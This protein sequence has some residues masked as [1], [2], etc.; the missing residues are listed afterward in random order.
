MLDELREA[1]QR[2]KA[3][4]KELKQLAAQQK[5]LDEQKQVGGWAGGGW[6]GVG[7]YG[8]SW[9]GW[10]AVAFGVHDAS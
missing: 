1:Q 8:R 3:L 5:A 2:L 9:V 4:E 10:Q 6:M 7:V